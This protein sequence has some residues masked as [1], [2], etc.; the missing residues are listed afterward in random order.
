MKVPKQKRSQAAP[1][2]RA[3][4]QPAGDAQR[5]VDEGPHQRAQRDRL[6]Q[7]QADG[8]RNG[9]PESLRSGIE[10]LS[11]LDMSDVRVHRDSARPAQLQAHAYAQGS[12]IYLAPGQEK[13]LPHEA[14]HVVQQKQGRVRPTMRLP[15]GAV[16]NDSAALEGE[17]DSMG[18]AAIVAGRYAPP[19]PVRAQAPA[20]TVAQGV[21]WVITD[22]EKMP[23]TTEKDIERLKGGSGLPASDFATMEHSGRRKHANAAAETMPTD[24]DLDIHVLAHGG[25][26]DK[27]WIG[28]LYLEEFVDALVNKYGVQNIEGRTLWMMVCHVGNAIDA[29]MKL[30]EGKGLQNVS[31]FIPKDFM[32]ISKQ[33]I[34]HVAGEGRFTDVKT[35]NKTVAKYDANHST[36][37]VAGFQPT[38]GGWEGRRLVSGRVERIGSL[39]VEEAI[40]N[41][42]DPEGLET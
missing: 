22:K 37:A 3:E 31:V 33:G 8:N 39:H 1:V 38:G 42:F 27:P 40:T 7:L 19:E 20:A 34:P 30:L 2:S 12:D 35:V 10:S 36:L 25:L 26:E 11:G 13:H 32:Y 9:L 15:D 16:M 23:E 21:L 29:F 6:A 28:G 24:Q 17:A 5:R 4:R 14:W 18:S 41:K